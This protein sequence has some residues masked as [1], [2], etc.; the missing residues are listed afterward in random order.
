MNRI[1]IMADS[2]RRDLLE[3]IRSASVLGGAAV[4]MYVGG[5]GAVDAKW[6]P[7]YRAKVR[8]VMAES[9]VVASALCGDMGG[10]GFSI[11]AENEWRVPETVKMMAL[12]RDLGCDILTTH[13]GV[14]PENAAHPRRQ[15]LKDALTALALEGERE[16]CRIAIETGPEKPETLLSFLESLPQNGVVGVN[17]DPANLVMVLGVDPVQGVRTLKG[18]IFH[19]HAKDGRMLQ[20]VGAE[21]VYGFFADGGIEDLR[22]GECFLETP[23]GQGDVDFPAWVRALDE[24]GYKGFVTIEREVGDSPERDIAEAVAFLQ[25]LGL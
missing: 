13:I 15:A 21:R 5:R 22:I 1:G 20:Y 17:Y 12:A 4:Q 25:K 7:A 11:P 6:T 8:D 19:T 18:R 14:I 24:T 16:G 3:G 2:F 23:L 9:S 10:H